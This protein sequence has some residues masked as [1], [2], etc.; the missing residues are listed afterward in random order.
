[1]YITKIDNFDISAIP[2]ASLMFSSFRALQS[3][4]IT[5]TNP[6]LISTEQMF[7]SC[8]QLV[9]LNLF[10]TSN[11][12]YMNSMFS[13]CGNLVNVP[14]FNTQ[15]VQTF[16]N[17]FYNCGKIV[18]APAFNTQSA[19]NLTTM[20]RSCSSLMSVPVYNTANVQ[21]MLNM[22]Q[23][24]SSLSDNSLNNILEM[25]INTTSAYTGTK[26]LRALGLNQAQTTRC[27]NLSNYSPFVNAG[28][29]TGY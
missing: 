1:M 18:E 2:N 8:S 22:F 10:D 9:N 4:T 26:T 15:S 17:M 3:V 21:N 7:S 27:Q 5:A 19:I 6:S 24:C 29:M 12:V 25:C 11:V 16:T 14:L 23:S 28:W 20:F 13:N